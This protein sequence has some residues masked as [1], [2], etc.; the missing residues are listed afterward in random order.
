MVAQMSSGQKPWSSNHLEQ[1]N[2]WA[3]IVRPPIM[4][5]TAIDAMKALTDWA[6]R[7]DE[8]AIRQT[9]VFPTRATTAVTE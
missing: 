8:K 5:D 2:H 3:G 6:K 1:K 7:V 9:I 4:S